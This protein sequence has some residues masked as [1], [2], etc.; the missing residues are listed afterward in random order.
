MTIPQIANYETRFEMYKGEVPENGVGAELGVCK[1]INAI[2]LLHLCRP[3]KLHLVDHWDAHP[4][5]R[6]HGCPWPGIWYGDHEELIKNF[7]D[8]EIVS[9]VVETHRSLTT[10]WLESIEDDTLDWIYIDA[11]HHYKDIKPELDLCVKKVKVGGLIMGDDYASFPQ[12]WGQGIVRAVNEY[13]NTGH[14][15][16]VGLSM[17]AQ[18]SYCC[19]L[20]KKDA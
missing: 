19:K 3:S 7:F 14:F 13:I 1:G 10:D 12:G 2:W 5:N 8:R 15:E 11:G 17:E 6:L 20:R 18:M 16:M 9:G 4:E